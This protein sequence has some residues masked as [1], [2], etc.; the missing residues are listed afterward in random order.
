M[1]FTGFDEQDF[2]FDKDKC[3][4]SRT[5]RRGQ[6]NDGCAVYY[7]TEYIY[8]INNVPKKYRDWVPEDLSKIV[9]EDVDLGVEHIKRL[10]SDANY[11]K[12]IY[13][14]G[15]VGS[16]KTSLGLVLL[17]DFLRR[18]IN[19]YRIM[20]YVENEFTPVLFVPFSQY[21][22]TYKARFSNKSDFLELINN[23]IYKS[24]LVMIDDIGFDGQTKTTLDLL[25]NIIDSA[26]ANDR[27]LILTGNLPPQKL[28]GVLGSRLHSRI[29][30]GCECYE[31]RS[32][33]LRSSF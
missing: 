20:E 21:A 26:L 3:T 9:K 2:V 17:N 18:M 15:N 22:E 19:E 4:V 7:K 32:S 23:N 27:G 16:G 14:Y 29:V 33:D 11:T 31:V 30:N 24:H 12:G 1:K 10:T 5:C 25:F 13:L 8:G 6:C 28:Q